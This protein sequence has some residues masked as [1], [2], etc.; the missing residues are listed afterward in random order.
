MTDELTTRLS[1]ALGATYAI[2]R[3]LGGGGMSRLF[4]ARDIVLKR[5]V[6]IKILPPDLTSEMGAAE[7][8]K[9]MPATLTSDTTARSLAF[10]IIAASFTLSRGRVTNGVAPYRWVLQYTHS[11][12]RGR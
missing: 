8:C 4:L 2:E 9:A 11:R 12:R 7:A 1:A 3:E 6:V 10:T 5:Q